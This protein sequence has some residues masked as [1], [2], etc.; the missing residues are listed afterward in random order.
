MSL[1]TPATV[2]NKLVELDNSLSHR[3]RIRREQRAVWFL[4]V[5]LAHSGDSWFW[6]AGL[7]LVW[8]LSRGEWHNRAAY[9]VVCILCMAI[10]VLAVKFTVRRSRPAGDWG[11]IYRN[12]D[13]HSFPSGHAARAFLLAIL[14]AGL[15]P[16][17]FA[18]ALV[19]WAPLVC[20]SRV[21]MGVHYLSDVAAGMVL[22]LGAGW[23]LLLARPFVIS[24]M[25]YLFFH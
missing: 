7:S 4:S 14:A 20:L 12:T 6:A 22:G 17:W 21:I 2:W 23:L 13:P 8:F 25:P 11:A 19:L 15:G 1:E 10:F 3:M 18:W 5:F 24:T 9:L 16:T